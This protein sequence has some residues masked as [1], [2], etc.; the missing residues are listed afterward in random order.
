MKKTPLEDWIV[1]R[2]RISPG[3]QTELAA[4]Q[5][6]KILET[7]DYVKKNSA[8]Y[9]K[10]LDLIGENT[11]SSLDDFKKI[12]F[13]YPE[14]IEKSPYSFLCVPQQKVDRIVT[15]NTSGTNGEKK[16]LFFTDKDLLLTVDFFNYGM[17]SLTDSTDRVLVLLPGNT[18][19]SIGDLLK[20]ALTLSGVSSTVYGLLSNLDEVEKIIDE[21]DINC[22]VGVPI[23]VLYFSRLKSDVFKRKIK[24]LLLSTDY[25]P[26][27]MINELNRNFNCPVFTHYGMT[28]MG[29][30]GGVECEALNGYHLREAD[31]YV[32][33]INPYS[34][35]PV[36]NGEVGEVV[37]TTLTREAMPLIRYRT[38]DIAAFSDK[39]CPCGTFLR[40][41]KRV[42]GRL[43]NRVEISRGAFLELKTLDEIILQFEEI[44]DYQAV[45]KDSNTLE[46]EIALY[47]ESSY[48]AVRRQIS[49]TIQETFPFSLNVKVNKNQEKKPNQL[50][51]SMLKRKI[52]DMRKERRNE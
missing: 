9:K 27:A 33:I 3:N 29:Y 43:E 45:L 48:P 44:I 46:L 5:F 17:R 40:T 14:D 6:K 11:I 32:E 51:N 35:A 28:E 41:L 52:S 31:L 49:T 47:D 25:V 18:Y 8:F 12:P 34:G 2:T 24:K 50:V 16:R 37:F 22:I 30:G 13:T 10:H 20:K 19:G 39:P 1:N 26:E 36:E 7:M 15:L 23:Q 42:E 38:G 4:Y 21:R